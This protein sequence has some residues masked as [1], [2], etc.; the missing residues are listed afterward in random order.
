MP[1]LRSPES[2]Y[3]KEMQK[4]N[5]PKRLGG[6][7]PDGYEHFPLMLSKAQKQ[8][9]GQYAVHQMPPPRWQFPPGVEGDAAFDQACRRAEEFTRACQLTVRNQH[10]HDRAVAQGWVLGQ[11]KALEEAQKWEKAIAD[12]AA[13]RHYEDRN[14]SEAAQ[15]EAAAAD[16]ATTDHV[17][18]VPRKRGRPKKTEAA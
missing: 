7:G 3:E 1:V 17:A 6:Y 4:W 5:T 12:A 18:E 15:R 14:M 8:P 11:E 2:E 10:E 13:H 9:N 16:N